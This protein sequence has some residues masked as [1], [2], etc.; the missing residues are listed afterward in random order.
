MKLHQGTFRLDI[1]KN[2]FSVVKQWHR[3]PREVEESMS[4]EVFKNHGDVAQRDTASGHGGDGFGLDFVTSVVFSAAQSLGPV[5]STRNATA[6]L[7][8]GCGS[9]LLPILPSLTA[10]G[11]RISPSSGGLCSPRL[12]KNSSGIGAS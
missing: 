4:L 6:V 8:S 11:L 10:E 2:F 3:L 9:H 5:T 1:R 7:M 12:T